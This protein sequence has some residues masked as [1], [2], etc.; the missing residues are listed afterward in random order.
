LHRLLLIVL[1]DYGFMWLVMV[2]LAVKRRLLLDPGIAV[3]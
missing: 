2:I 3:P 1:S